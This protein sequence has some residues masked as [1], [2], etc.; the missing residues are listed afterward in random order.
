MHLQGLAGAGRP[1]PVV[2]NTSP[3]EL[4]FAWQPAHGRQRHTVGLLCHMT[5]LLHHHAC[6]T[7][8]LFHLKLRLKQPLSVFK[9]TWGIRGPLKSLQCVTIRRR[10][11]KA[12]FVKAPL[13]SRYAHVAF[14]RLEAHV[15]YLRL[16]ECTID[17][18]HSRAQ[19]A[20]QAAKCSA[21][22]KNAAQTL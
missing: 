16:E 8:P 17:T 6:S 19:A 5:H 10:V 12:T 18:S 1:P 3:L 21:A 4:S 11:C 13:K 20:A 7:L 22:G 2:D 9:L 14:L 15:A